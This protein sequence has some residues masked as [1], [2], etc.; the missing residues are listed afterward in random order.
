MKKLITILLSICFTLIIGVSLVACNDNQKNNG[1]DNSDK[2]HVHELIYH[3]FK[4]WNCT[5]SGNNPYYSC[6]GCEACFDDESMQIVREESFYLQPATGHYFDSGICSCGVKDPDYVN[7][8]FTKTQIEYMFT[9]TNFDNIT[10]D[11]II[12]SG[13]LTIKFRIINGRDVLYYESVDNGEEIAQ[14]VIYDNNSQDLKTYTVKYE[15][16][17]FAG[18][19]I[20]C[21]LDENA[22]DTPR[23]IVE[24]FFETPSSILTHY[25][26]M[27]P[28]V[29]ES[30]D[31]YYIENFKQFG[32]YFIGLKFFAQSENQLQR[33]ERYRDEERTAYTVYNF[34]QT[35]ISIPLIIDPD[36]TH[37]YTWGEVVE[38]A[39]CTED[40]TERGTCGE[41]GSTTT[42]LIDATGHEY[43][44]KWTTDKNYHWKE[45][46]CGCVDAGVD[47]KDEHNYNEDECFCGRKSFTEGLEYSYDDNKNTCTVIG[48]GEAI[49]E[50][51]IVIPSNVGNY[52]V[53]E[54]G[55][56]AFANQTQISQI[57]L[58]ETIV[59]IFT[60]AFEGCTG[61]TSIEI[62]K[63]AIIQ[64]DAFKFCSG[65]TK[66]SLPLGESKF[67]SIFGIESYD[68]A[69]GTPIYSG[70]TT[71]YY[72]PN[73][74]TSI[75]I[76]SL[77]DKTIPESAFSN[78]KSITD[79]KIECD[80]N[81]I[82]VS[83]FAGCTGL[84]EF[85]IP[86]GVSQIDNWAFGN[87]ALT[88]IEL[89]ES[90]VT[91]A[92]EAFYDCK[93]L[94]SI[95]VPN[96]VTSIGE[97]A[98]RG[99]SSLESITL[100]FVG[101]SRTATETEKL[102]GYIFGQSTYEGGIATEQK[103]FK[104]GTAYTET[105]YLP[106]NLT[107]VTMTDGDVPGYAFFNCANL[108]TV[109]IADGV[110]TIGSYIVMDCV[111][112]TSIIISETVT[113]FG[114]M[115][116]LN[117]DNLSKIYYEGSESDWNEIIFDFEEDKADER[118]YIYSETEPT[119]SGKYWHYAEDGVP[120]V[121]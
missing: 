89:P 53:T 16:D 69:Y 7:G 79:I 77:V 61:L 74:L 96:N 121:W 38:P 28:D 27:V 72:I 12:D 26:T 39:T 104:S 41:C 57:T 95:T 55:R 106:E 21:E 109:H 51:D 117:C 24:G 103:Y 94:K 46:V 35:Q 45:A 48:I 5:E 71:S 3:E 2:P 37:S 58:P 11:Y 60:Y 62:P 54:I 67:G 32:N 36:H 73:G 99:C 9:H 80:I 118:V 42:R 19:I 40:G 107:S 120:I 52:I 23:D 83:A 13:Y 92:G 105:F 87:T 25:Y 22:E 90:L 6:K 56:S 59:K 63:N 111:S 102:F 119:E 44:E 31:G 75:T 98:F 33:V 84:T 78:C 30:C 86:Q 68:G 17:G 49:G 82:G 114:F 81:V 100:P 97:G 50:T 29:F 108:K 91:I 10:I 115:P 113:E 65:L 110:E 18:D 20:E 4:D 15:F 64:S 66:M 85:K 34:N 70:T 76:V 101:N 47:E 8:K 43:S 1:D 112:V 14:Y 116:F 93:F 88:E